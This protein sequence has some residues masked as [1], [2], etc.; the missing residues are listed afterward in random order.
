MTRYTLNITPFVEATPAGVD[1]G[2]A[3]GTDSAITVTT[4]YI[5]LGGT[6]WIPV[7]GE[8]HYARDD[9]SV[10]ERE[11]RK[12]KAGGVNIVAT[13]S[14]WI[15]HEE[16]RG[17][18]VWHGNRD[19]RRFVELAAKIGLRVVARIGPW[20][21][22]ETRNGGFP[23]WLQA[24]PIQHRTND[25]EYLE[26]VRDWYRDIG[27][28]LAG[29]MHSVDNPD[30]PVIGIQVENELYDQ[31]AHLDTLRVIA[32]EVGLRSSLWIAT[33]WG[34]AQLPA[35]RLMPVYAGYSDGFWEEADIEWPSFGKLHFTF[36]TERDDLSVG[37]D[38]RTFAAVGAATDYGY[39]YVT[40]E[41]GGGM[42]AAYHRRPLVDPADVA[43]LA[44]TKLGS[45][46]A[47]Q[48]Y[49][50]Y[51]GVVQQPGVLSGT[52]ESHE[53]GYP[54]DLPLIDYDF[55]APIGSHGQVRE[56]YHLLRQQHLF[57]EQYGPTLAALPATI[58]TG[59]DDGPRWSVR[60]DDNRGFLFVNN[61]QPAAEL[62]PAIADVQFEARFVNG[63]VVVPAEPI[64]VPAD[65]YFLWPM[66]QSYGDIPS[67]TATVQPITELDGP[68]GRVALFAAIAGIPVEFHL[69]GRDRAD[70][71]GP[72]TIEDTEHGLLVRLTA[73]PGPDTVVTV[74]STSLVILDPA[75]A[76][77]LWRGSVAGVDTLL[78]WDESLI[79]D[80]GV[81]LFTNHP[82]SQLL[83]FPRLNN[84]S[85]RLREIGTSP[86]FTRYTVAGPDD[87]RVQDVSLVS[88]AS[89]QVPVRLGGSSGRLSAPREADYDHAAIFRIDINSQD[90]DEG[91]QWLLRVEWT[92]DVGRILIDGDVVSDQ[93]WSGRAWDVD[94]TPYR[95]RLAAGITVQALPWQPGS[96]V[97]VDA[98]V[99]PV[100]RAPVAE[101]RSAALLS[102]RAIPAIPA[103][104][105][106]QR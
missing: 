33:G 71:A 85:G 14:I 89:G 30:A 29:L 23:D 40:C 63:P 28:Q 61:R 22:G 1:M 69:A 56:H 60:G 94:L 6:P 39:P 45:G 87:A 84:S 35:N 77:R 34:G 105:A 31:P 100:S 15:L 37:A 46:S 52:Q 20:V 81:T 80:D 82:A 11:L 83:T 2:D 17:E 97:F 9:E 106:P 43:A 54:N 66:N 65:S 73:E 86:L 10:W 64:T 19:L 76:S 99:R 68:V 101:I 51:H 70:V 21:H 67:L 24:L 59:L 92:G 98:R 75:S 32:E 96:E 102:I 18:R 49:Y 26:L 4:R 8:Y 48:G 95:G 104:E 27:T 62:L 16:I 72:V 12:L 103:A 58:P 7:M 41:L 47:W 88:P 42:Q 91:D 50:L 44:L 5:E 74:G 53:N 90:L 25:P 79:F 36:S 13:Y 78:V 3:P 93:F 57:L 55:F 38:L